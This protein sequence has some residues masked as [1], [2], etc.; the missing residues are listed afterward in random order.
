[1]ELFGGHETAIKMGLKEP[2][3]KSLD[4]QLDEARTSIPK[5]EEFKQTCVIATDLWCMQHPKPWWLE[6]TQQANK[7]AK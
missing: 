3:S 5:S 7:L 4:K 1:L 6:V 2:A